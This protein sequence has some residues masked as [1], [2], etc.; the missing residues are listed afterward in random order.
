MGVLISLS[1][2]ARDAKKE[3]L[4]GHYW[5]MLVMVDKVMVSMVDQILKALEAA[6]KAR[7]LRSVPGTVRS[8]QED[9]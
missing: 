7:E 1:G 5:Q 8:V 3:L 6:R 4:M 2:F 9:T